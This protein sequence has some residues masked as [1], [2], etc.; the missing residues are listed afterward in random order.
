[1]EKRSFEITMSRL[2]Y[3]A[4]PLL[5]GCL[6]GSLVACGNTKP[7]T[8]AQILDRSVRSPMKD[9]TFTMDLKISGAGGVSFNATGNGKLMTNP[10]RSTI[11]LTAQLL[12]VT[13]DSDLVTADGY[14]YD[15]TAPNTR[16]TKQ[17]SGTSATGV[18]L[19]YGGMQ[20][21]SLVAIETVNGARTYHLKGKVK[22]AATPTSGST[23]ASSDEEVWVRT[24]NF[25]PIKMLVHDASTD[26][27]S[28]ATM[29]DGTIVFT[30][31]DSH[32]KI[33][34]PP[35]DQVDSATFQ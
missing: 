35:A 32:V 6:I 33:D 23:E 29:V 28:G 30:A 34:I 11:H 18:S 22:P 10:D 21:V 14:D 13:I 17:A 19:D 27:T 9:A 20:E 15:K 24:D 31:W 12:G 2:L 5:I 26:P 7:L 25:Y 16:W 4:S 8:A 1:M 3:R